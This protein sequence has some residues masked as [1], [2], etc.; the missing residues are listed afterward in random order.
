[1]FTGL[2]GDPTSPSERKS[3]LNIHWKDWYWSWNSNTLA[4]WCKEPTYL[5]RSWCW[6]R[7]RAGGERDDRGWVGWMALPTRRTWV[8]ASS[9]SWWWTV[10]P[11]VLQSVGLQ[12]VGDDWVTEL[13]GTESR[14]LRE[15]QRCQI[16]M[17]IFELNF[18]R[19]KGRG[20]NFQHSRAVCQRYS[21][22]I[23]CI[24]VWKLIATR[25]LLILRIRFLP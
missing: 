23:I 19:E 17:F 15:K 8:W 10:N 13:N 7:L 1:M 16:S 6:E 20:T 12:T 25:T 9:R 21:V 14:I 11:G 24:L 18:S 22:V 5:K 2:Q 3:V 4:T